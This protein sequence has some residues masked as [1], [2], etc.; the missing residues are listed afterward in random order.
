MFE[1]EES[2]VPRLDGAGDGTETSKKPR[3]RTAKQG[4]FFFLLS[5]RGH[6]AIF[7]PGSPNLGLAGAAPTNLFEVRIQAYGSFIL[8]QE[9]EEHDLRLGDGYQY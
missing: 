2:T 6:A 1:R 7:S 9:H 4:S 8:V 3:G 5:L